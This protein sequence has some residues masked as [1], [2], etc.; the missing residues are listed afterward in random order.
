VK[1]LIVN[2]DDLGLSENVDLGIIQ[3]HRDG[4]VT[5]A[6]FLSCGNSY[7]HAA[8]LLR[9]NP[10]LGA[11][12]HLCLTRE[13]PVLDP[14]KLPSLTAHGRFYNGPGGLM[15]RLYL[16][17]VR[18]SE[19]YE[20]FSAQVERAVSLGIKPTHL[21]G[22]QHIHILPGIAHITVEVAKRFGVPAIRYPVG[23]VAGPRGIGARVEKFALETLARTQKARLDRAGMHYPDRFYGL[24][25]T[26]S[27]DAETVRRIIRSLSD[28]TSELMCHPGLP[29][30]ALA[31]RTGWGYGWEGEL[32][33][34]TAS[35]LRELAGECGVEL[36][37]YGA[38]G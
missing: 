29:D 3:A 18:R 21:D 31:K 15:T 37:G 12:V 27:L 7:E 38:L 34:V 22:H 16:G 17:A 24:A 10:G 35:G 19:I 8:T 26:G 5:S 33:A 28:G 9:D 6:T 4:I 13:R 23:P 25:E 36:V 1:R 32:N 14:S 20:E 30:D 2:A 11:G